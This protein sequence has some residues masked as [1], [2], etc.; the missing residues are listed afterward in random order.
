[1]S[2]LEVVLALLAVALVT[3][4]ALV[5]A[6]RGARGGSRVAFALRMVAVVATTVTAGRVAWWAWQDGTGA[7]TLALVGV[8][9]AAA[10]LVLAFTLARRPSRVVTWGAA[11]VML[12][13]SLL[14]GLGAGLFFLGP[15]VLMVVAAVASTQDGVASRPVG[16]R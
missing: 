11:V 6:G 2:L 14:T 7:F 8:P 4:L 10:V 5:V 9:M 3:T 13:W 15:A 12:A 16:G 1:M